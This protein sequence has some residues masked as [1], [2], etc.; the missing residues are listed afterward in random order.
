[1]TLIWLRVYTTYEILGFFFG[2]NKTNV[3]DNLKD[4]LATLQSMS[5]FAFDAL[6]P[7]RPKLRSPHAVMDA[8]L[9]FVW[10][11]MPKSSAS[12][13]TKGDTPALIS[14]SPT[15][16]QKKAHTLKNQVG[17]RPDG[18]HID[19]L[20]ESRATPTTTGRCCGR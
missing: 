8:F 2:L 15:I 7:E 17:V 16:G 20:S 9:T 13:S 5:T 4:V 10:S 14:R 11:L 12:R 3:E 18:A 6:L 1:M 19:A